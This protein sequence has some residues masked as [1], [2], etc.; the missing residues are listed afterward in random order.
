MGSKPIHVV[1][2]GGSLIVP[3]AVDV[4]F[5]KSFRAF[6]L[7]RIRKE[8]LCIITGGGRTARNYASAAAAVTPLDREDLD[9]LGI[10]A[11]RL[12]AHLIRTILRDVAHPRIVK[13]PTEPVKF[14]ED[15]LVAAG[16]KP[17]C[18]TDYDAVLLA[19]RLGARLLVNLTNTDYVYDKDPRRFRDAKPLKALSWREFRKMVGDTW[20]PGM[21]VPFDPVASR[22]ASELGMRVLIINGKDLAN[23]AAALDGRPFTGTTIG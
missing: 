7:Q 2:L 3:E 1:S 10:H 9:W 12:N 5:L 14:T 13:N 16:W 4:G 15:V 21:N 8:R 20:D 11:T 18:S 17:G 22:R 19:E 6:V 23:L